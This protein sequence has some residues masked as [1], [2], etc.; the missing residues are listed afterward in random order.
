[1]RIDRLYHIVTITSL[2]CLCIQLPAQD[3]FWIGNNGNWNDAANWSTTSGGAADA[4]V[5]TIANDVIFDNN[6]GPCA[7]MN[8]AVARSILQDNGQEIRIE[9]TL[10]ISGAYTFVNGTI[11]NDGTIIAA[12]IISDGAIDRDFD[13]SDGTIRISAIAPEIG[14]FAFNSTNLTFDGIDSLIFQD[15]ELSRLST[16]GSLDNINYIEFTTDGEIFGDHEFDVL[17]VRNSKTLFLNNTSTQR[18]LDEIVTND[19]CN[20]YATISGFLNQPDLAGLFFSISNSRPEG[21]VFRRIR[22]ETASGFGLDLRESIDAGENENVRT[23]ANPDDRVLYWVGGTGEWFDNSNWSLTSGGPGGEC[24]PT[25]QDDVIFDLN[26]FNTNTDVVSTLS[27]A[28]CNNFTYTAPENG[29]TIDLPT[30]FVSNN[31]ILENNFNWA[32]G[33]TILSGDREAGASRQQMVRTSGTQLE[34]LRIYSERNIELLDDLNVQFDITI[35]GFD[36]TVNFISNGHDITTGRF[37]AFNNQMGLDLRDSYI[38]V[39][40]SEI[41]TEQPLTISTS[42]ITSVENTQWELSAQVTGLETNEGELGS[43]WFSDPSGL[44]RAIALTPL[45]SPNFRFSGDGE[46]FGDD[47]ILDSLIFSPG[48]TYQID[49]NN[50]IAVNSYFESLGDVCQPITFSSFESGTQE[51]LIIPASATIDMSF[52]SISD[53][54]ATGGNA[55]DA[56]TGSVDVQGNSGWSFRDPN[57]QDVNRFLGE[58]QVICN[59]TEQIIFDLNFSDD[60]VDSVIWNGNEL[61]ISSPFTFELVTLGVRPSIIRNV[62]AEVFFTNG[63]SQSDTVNI[64]FNE[65]ISFDLGSDTTLCNGSIAQFNIPI[66]DAQYAWST[67]EETQ[68]IFAFDPDTY[69]VRVDSGACSFSDTIVVEAVDLSALR[70]G[71]DT[72]ICDNG[73]LTLEAPSGFSGDILWSDNSTGNSIT[74]SQSGIFWAEFSEGNCMFRD[75]VEVIFD[76]A[77]DVN[78]GNDTTLCNGAS[79]TLNTGLNAGN[80]LWSTG[81]T[82]PSISIT[83]TDTYTVTVQMGSCVATDTIVIQQVFLD[84]INLGRDTTFCMGEVPE[85]SVPPDFNGDFIWSTGSTDRTISVSEEDLYSLTLVEDICTVS[86][87]ILIT[88]DTPRQ[89]DLG[90][91]TTLCQG[92][93]LNLRL[94]GLPTNIT[95]A[96]NWSTGESNVDNITVDQADTYTVQVFLEACVTFDT[97]EVDVLELPSF[98]L[99]QDTTICGDQSVTLSAPP[100]A[101]QVLWSTGSTDS[102][103]DVNQTD[104]YWL[105]VS[106]SSCSIRDTI[107]VNVDDPFV[108]NIGADT[109]LCTGETLELIATTDLNDQVLWSTG[110]MTPTLSVNTIGDVSVQVTRGVCTANDTIDVSVIDVDNFSIGSDTTLCEGE[111]LTLN[112]ALSSQAT[113]LWQDG[114]TDETFEVD[115][116]GTFTVTASI[117]RCEATASL[118]VDFQNA[119]ALDLGVDTTICSPD[120]IELDAGIASAAYIWQDGSTS[121]TLTADQTDLYIVEVDDGICV[122]SDSVS[123]TI[124]DRPNLMI[125]ADDSGAICEGDSIILSA[126]TPD[127][128]YVWQDGT[129]ETQFIADEEG[130]FVATMTLEACVVVDSFDLI[131]NANPDATLPADTS[132]CEGD[133]F[134]I[135]LPDNGEDFVWTGINS[136]SNS[137]SLTEAGQYSVLITDANGCQDEDSF[138]LATRETPTF[139]LGDDQVICDGDSTVLSVSRS[140]PDLTWSVP[141]MGDFLTIELEDIYWAEAEI[142]GCVFRDSVLVEVQELPI[143]DLGPDTSVCQGAMI[144]LDATNE[145]ATYLWSTNETTPTI[146]PALTG[147]GTAL[148]VQ[149]D[150]RGCVTIDDI[151]ISTME[152]PQFSLREDE[153]I[154]DNETVT[155]EVDNPNG[156]WDIE[157]NTGETT[158]EIEVSEG[159]TF[160]ATATIDGCSSSDEFVLDVQPLPV[161]DLGDDFS[162]CEELT[163]QLSV[164][165]NDV[166]VVWSDGTTGNQLIVS[167]PGTISAI[168]TTSLGCQFEDEIEVSNREC[169]AFSIYVPNAFSPNQ[170]GRNDL[171]IASVPEGIFLSEYEL[172]IFDRFGGKVFETFD[173]NIGWDGSGLGF[174]SLQ[175]GVYAYAIRVRYSDDFEL[176]IEETMTGTLTLVE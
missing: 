69:F 91:D 72:T 13:S 154:C 120:V 159:G 118:I 122:V 34:N 170:D 36:P 123:I 35:S 163:A 78:L 73:V 54:R 171:F 57:A 52:T 156:R 18:I 166:S 39:T 8:D 26:S 152:T 20:G 157:W 142:N 132:I 130:L 1:M 96:A 86:D 90:N 32:I 37:F 106:E 162:K 131:V 84:S 93:E 41:D 172:Q 21:F 10:T 117:Q 127:V 44:G 92:E 144:T 31:L 101:A 27:S 147:S 161:F 134:V 174:Q 11:R 108:V 99:G 139:S 46:I 112:A 107:N 126:N 128:S 3:L 62:R 9:A 16:T 50:A 58:D 97:I 6:S 145:G 79:L 66:D 55:F 49:P 146:T 19:P 51:E 115:S 103:I 30:I 109:T 64:S 56:G 17:R 133:T 121:Q 151:N 158:D 53:I 119:P 136:M 116:A 85:L 43:V 77:F 141:N 111:A 70:I 33:F 15:A 160:T 149:V 169:V 25:I 38:L 173:I 67:G 95:F 143:V 80:I 164:D 14:T 83:D 29:I 176:D 61:Q 22:F 65:A 150:I 5:P 75:S 153:T 7:I 102:S 155:L 24:V 114:S 129:T 88:F 68:A 82:T 140:F 148:Q 42:A 165:R 71:N 87:T 23:P 167:Q 45:S 135:T 48:N 81:E 2:L 138:E 175:P 28:F 12:A 94:E 4:N 105:E 74:A 104:L 60:D 113:Y 63:C 124:Q 40:G 47:Y 59:D 110:D 125:A 98:S 168:A 76:N 137:V 89:F 100:N